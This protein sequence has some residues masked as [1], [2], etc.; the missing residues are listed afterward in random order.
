M[1]LDATPA[2]GD[3][4]RVVLTAVGAMASWYALVLLAFG[5][6]VM[7]QPTEVPDECSGFGC[8]SARE[9]TLWLGFLFGVPMMAFSAVISMITLAFVLSRRPRSGVGAGTF[10]A[11][12]GLVA[13]ICGVVALAGAL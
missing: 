1:A 2:A 8:S 6:L 5:L 7:L 13:T 9:A 4:Q 10:A 3:R 12:T 11:L